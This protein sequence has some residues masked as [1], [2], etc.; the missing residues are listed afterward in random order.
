MQLFHWN[1]Q[2]ETG[3]DAVDQQHRQLLQLINQLGMAMT[4]L[5][6]L[7][8][9]TELL[10][11][12]RNY[13]HFHFAEEESLFDECC[14]SAYD[15]ELHQAQH[16]L[17]CDKIATLDPANIPDK[18]AVHELHQFLVTWLIAHIFSEDMKLSSNRLPAD[19]VP[20]TKRHLLTVS[21]MEKALIWALNES[22]RR[23]RFLTDHAPMLIWA[24]DQTGQR[25]Y[26]NH[27]WTS[28]LGYPVHQAEH[29]WPQ[30]LHQDDRENYQATVHKLLATGQGGDIEVRYITHDGRVRVMHEKVIPRIQEDGTFLGLIASAMDI[31]EIKQAIRQQE[32]ANSLLEQEVDK[33][34][35]EINRLMLT[36]PL[37]QTGNRRYLDEHLSCQL[38][39]ANETGQPLSL[40]FFDIDHFKRI[41]D[42]YGHSTGDKVLV[43][44][45]RQIRDSLR[46][47]DKLARFGGEEFVAILPM[48]RAID[49]AEVAQR[50]LDK[51]RQLAL[52]ELSGAITFSAGVAQAQP[53]DDNDRLL[54]RCDIA[55]YQ[56][57]DAGRNRIVTAESG[58][59]TTSGK[60]DTDIEH[61]ALKPDA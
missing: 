29:H 53:G 34:T 20:S 32:R 45:A 38:S 9:L 57:K 14:L 51:C 36:D 19:R 39:H 8:T 25:I 7:P 48:T 59:A 40:I 50:I 13:A 18:E 27:A 42:H 10:Q 55:L 3:I 60:V 4:T 56:A 47:N 31:T 33:R 44:V 2:L 46:Q 22:E 24:T 26:F 28:E 30:W 58:S 15:I 52:P 35:A 6:N 41:N 49:A 17:F 21:P 61:A 23:F 54:R 11:Q 5:R 1:S 37:T 16:Q 12:L 43:E